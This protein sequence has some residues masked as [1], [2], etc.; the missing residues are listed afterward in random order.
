MPTQAQLAAV[1]HAR[2][3]GEETLR[4]WREFQLKR[5]PEIDA[6][7]QRAGILRSISRKRRRTCLAAATRTN[8]RR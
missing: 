7:L 1:A 5:P 8:R 6:T 4:A 2:E 3:E